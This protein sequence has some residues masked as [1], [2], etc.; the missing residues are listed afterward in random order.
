MASSSS[1]VE[2][3][4]QVEALETRLQELIEER[5]RVDDEISRVEAERDDLV[6]RRR[7]AEE[8]EEEEVCAEE[9]AP[10]D[11]DF[12]SARSWDA[13][14]ASMAREV[15][16]ISSFRA[17]QREVI[18]CVLE[19]RDAF[20][21][22][23][24]GG[25]K[26]LTYQLPAL[27]GGGVTVVVSPL[28]SLML[29]QAHSF[30]AKC[31]RNAAVVAL[32]SGMSAAELNA[33]LK[34]LASDAADATVAFVTPE[35]VANSKRLMSS[36]EKLHKARRL[37]RFV[38]DECHCASQWGHDYRPDYVKLGALRRTFPEV[39]ILAL[40]AT[41]TPRLARDVCQI[42]GLAVKKTVHFRGS[43]DR[44]NLFF[45]VR[46]KPPSAPEALD[47]LFAFVRDCKATSGI[48]YC[49]SQKECGDVAAGL[50]SRG[51]RAAAYH[52]GLHDETRRR[53]HE[54][55][56]VGSI[57]VVAATVAFGLGIDKPDCRFVAHFSMP[58]SLES[59]YQEMGRA[60]RDGLPARVVLFFSA[61]DLWRIL[62]LTAAEAAGAT[63]ALEMAKYCLEPA[64]R[65]RVLAKALG[66]DPP[67]KSSDET[68]CDVCRSGNSTRQAYDATVLAATVSDIV[69][70]PDAPRRTAKQL[71]DEI[72]RRLKPRAV[73]KTFS[74][75]LLETIVARFLLR[76]ILALDLSYTAYS[77]VVYLKPGRRASSR[78]TLDCSLVFPNFISM[79]TADDI[80]MKIP[81]TTTTTTNATKRKKKE[82]MKAPSQQAR[83]PSKK[84]TEPPPRPDVIDLVDDDDDEIRSRARKKIRV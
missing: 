1:S 82:V 81:T 14:V 60:G 47:A 32:Y 42:L 18:N 2:T 40:T 55:W 58:R 23:R 28:V 45:E 12:A 25:G 53:V 34:E 38:V 48:V 33:S 61:T 10:P 3:A 24:T 9:E 56:L 54:D 70:D 16:G 50:V 29:D 39:R 73:E 84:T 72:R 57:S 17:L 46:A 76:N 79:P 19:D 80:A 69:L 37:R 43:T 35:R 62:S 27:F 41:A 59:Y 44:P 13:E 11:A 5:A 7:I 30:E 68:C 75:D 26:S 31:G 49:L 66:D 4:R 36:L 83:V 63:N 21:V 15:F 77:V 51:C 71:V 67:Q 20:V 64:C 22:M 52:A 6:R 65:R 78:Q 8:E 74:K